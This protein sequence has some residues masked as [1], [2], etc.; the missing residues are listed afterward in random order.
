LLG[1]PRDRHQPR[2]A[3][4]ILDA[5]VPGGLQKTEAA[6]AELANKGLDG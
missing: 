2:G 3:A 5:L 1:C 4:P 6:R